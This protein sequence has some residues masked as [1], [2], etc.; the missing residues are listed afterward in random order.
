MLEHLEAQILKMP[1]LGT[2]DVGAFLASMYVPVCP[3]KLCIRHCKSLSASRKSSGFVEIVFSTI[4]ENFARFISGSIT[5]F[6]FQVLLLIF[7][8]QADGW[9][10]ISKQITLRN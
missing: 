8:F 10:F 3:K 9:Q 5:P 7:V 1:P 4:V 2:N 6:R